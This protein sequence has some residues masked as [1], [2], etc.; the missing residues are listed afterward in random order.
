ME[1]GRT[2]DK[3]TVERQQHQQIQQYMEQELDEIKSTLYSNA[4]LCH[5]QLKNWGFCKEDSDEALTYNKTNIKAWYRLAKA[6]QMLQEW[7]VG[8]SW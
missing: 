5:L 4:A 8:R 1:N 6:H 7:E 3:T 2:D